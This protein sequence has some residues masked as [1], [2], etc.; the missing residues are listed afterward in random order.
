MTDVLGLFSFMDC[1]MLYNMN[2][3]L[4]I[5]ALLENYCTVA[6]LLFYILQI[7]NLNKNNKFFHDAL[8]AG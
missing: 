6:L 7:Y 3:Y 5:L 4:L 8:F 2:N 1:F